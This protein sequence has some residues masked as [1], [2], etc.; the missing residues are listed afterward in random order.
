MQILLVGV[1][2]AA[3][4]RAREDECRCSFEL[5]GLLLSAH[6]LQSRQRLWAQYSEPPRL[7]Q[8]VIR[9]PAREVEQLF[10]RLAVERLAAIVLVRAAR[11]NGGLDVH[12]RPR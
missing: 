10:D 6:V 9:R 7:R 3:Q 11:A 4:L 12:G 2:V 5:R 1:G 8:V